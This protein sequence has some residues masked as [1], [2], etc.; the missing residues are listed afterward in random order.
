MVE[1]YRPLDHCKPSIIQ[2]FHFVKLQNFSALRVAVAKVVYLFC[3]HYCH[4]FWLITHWWLVKCRGFYAHN[5]EK[6]SDEW[7]LFSDH[8]L[9]LKY[10]WTCGLWGCTG[11]VG[12]EAYFSLCF[13]QAL[14]VSDS[15]KPGQS[16]QNY[17]W[18]LWG[19]FTELQHTASQCHPT[20]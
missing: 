8:M 13:Y 12:V 7:E 4:Y 20:S 3:S 18:D 15:A 10:S 16:G 17:W 1:K 11:C 19:T 9:R 5:S 2:F 14:L 6:R